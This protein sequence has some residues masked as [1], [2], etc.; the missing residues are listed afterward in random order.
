MG[1]LRE[2]WLE[3]SVYG[4]GASTYAVPYKNK[5]WLK[6]IYRDDAIHVREVSPK[7]PQVL[8]PGIEWTIKILGNLGLTALI[9]DEAKR[10]GIEIGEEK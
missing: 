5:D 8:A 9:I 4:D 3:N 7:D 2:F 1:R 6:S 10:Q